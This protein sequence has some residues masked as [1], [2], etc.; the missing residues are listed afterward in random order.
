MGIRTV[1]V[2][3]DADAHAMHVEGADTALHID[4]YLNAPAILAAARD[5]H[6]RA[7]HP[8]YGFLSENPEF[9]QSVIDA[10]LVWVGPSPEA[11]R[12]L[13][14]KAAAKSLAER[15]G[16]PI[17]PGFHGD[18]Q[19]VETLCR[20]AERVGYPVLIKASAGGGGRGMRAVI[21]AHEFPE[22]LEAA[23][24]EAMAAF[25]D[26][27]VLLERYV[28]RPRHVEVQVV[29][30]QHGHLVHLGE[31][32]CSV[33]RRHQK[34]I[35]ETPSPAVDATLRE[36]MGQAA[37]S[38][39][40]AAGYSNAG[41]VEFLLDEHGEFA[42]LEVNARL[43]VE[44]PVTEAVTGLDLV[45]LQL[46]VAGGEPLPLSQDDVAFSGH[47]LEVRVIAEDPLAGWVPSSG[48]ITHFEV[49][50][51]VRVDTWVRDDATVSPYYDSLLAKV[52]A[53]APTRNQALGTLAEALARTRIDG[54]RNNV[55]LLLA[56][57]Q[58][59]EFARGDLSTQFLEEHRVLDRV[60]DTPPEVIAAA[61]AL[62]H[63]LQRPVT[64]PWRSQT[65]WRIARLDQPVGWVRAAREYATRVTADHL[66]HSVNV[67]G[68]IVRAVGQRLSV[69]DSPVVVSDHD[70]LRVVNFKG[71][72]YRLIRAA[73]P[74]I[75]ATATGQGASFSE[76]R[77][78][79]PMPGRVVKVAVDAGQ[80]VTQNQPLLVLEAMKMEHVVESP[81]AGVVAEVHVSVGDQVGSGARLLTLE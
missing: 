9:A 40:R 47:A 68:H 14:A 65:S 34:L 46:R 32:E 36:R 2:Y 51:P 19:S 7:I 37:V 17:L 79:A 80:H 77:L 6:A 11:M 78:V 21:S 76:G 54:V 25:G 73:P 20:E 72:A 30:D 13:G 43:Q 35:E 12:A 24:R 62:D 10:R 26:A 33:Q 59:P 63:L 38:L 52:I 18:D 23:K 81:H 61:S 42:F 1:A 22:A 69:D 3:S 70:G 60:G 48:T 5:S 27:R 39:A 57:L 71:R 74:T 31:R 67:D 56:T 55:D 41:T 28:A 75:E 16:V 64:D 49:P 45:E 66:G 8:G 44:H 29:G 58:T 50:G 4:S 53:H 15:C